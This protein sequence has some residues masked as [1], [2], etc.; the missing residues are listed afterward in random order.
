MLTLRDVRGDNCLRIAVKRGNPLI[1]NMLAAAAGP[2]GR[3]ELDKFGDESEAQFL[4]D[5]G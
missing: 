1:S 3:T 4:E 5:F 2:E